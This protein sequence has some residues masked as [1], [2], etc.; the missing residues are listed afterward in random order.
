MAE[1]KTDKKTWLFQKH[2][3]DTGSV[4]MQ[5]GK[6]TEEIKHLQEHIALHKKDFDSKRSL[7]KKVAKRRT[8]LRYI[9]SKDLEEYAA[10]SKK[11]GLKV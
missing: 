10:I 1:K 5:I 11:I 2:E 6:L 9:K 4:Q 3:N 8:F 7:L